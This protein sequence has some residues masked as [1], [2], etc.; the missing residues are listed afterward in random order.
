MIQVEGVLHQVRSVQ[1]G[2]YWRLLLPGSYN[3]TITAA[4]YVSQTKVNIKVT[5]EN[6]TNVSNCIQQFIM[7]PEDTVVGPSS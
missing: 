4:G 3:V 2:A 1:H 6:T 7:Y 5:N